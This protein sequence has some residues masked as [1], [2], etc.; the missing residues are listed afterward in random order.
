MGLPMGV[1]E[2]SMG[3][4]GERGKK[5]GKKRKKKGGGGRVWEGEKRRGGKGGLVERLTIK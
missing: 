5:K 4:G 3:G 1:G 2:A